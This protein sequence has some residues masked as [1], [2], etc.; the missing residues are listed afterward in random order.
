VPEVPREELLLSSPDEKH[1]CFRNC[2]E[3][4]VPVIGK[5]IIFAG[6]VVKFMAEARKCVFSDNETRD[7]VWMISREQ[8]GRCTSFVVAEDV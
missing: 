4:Q 6:L 5:A 3:T 8:H 7:E 1:C 2:K